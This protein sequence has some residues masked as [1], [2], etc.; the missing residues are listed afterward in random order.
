MFSI[1][2]IDLQNANFEIVNVVIISIEMQWQRKKLF[3][4][5]RVC[6]IIKYVSEMSACFSDILCFRAFL[7][8]N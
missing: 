4:S 7:T 2:E 3:L 8:M 6:V 1:F 5:D